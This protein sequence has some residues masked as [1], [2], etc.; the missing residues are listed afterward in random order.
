MAATVEDLANGSTAPIR[1]QRRASSSAHGHSSLL[2]RLSGLQTLPALRQGSLK[3]HLLGSESFVKRL[4]QQPQLTGHDGCVNTIAWDETGEYLLSG[5]DDRCLNIYRPMDPSS[6]LVHSIP[7]GHTHNIFSAKF[8]T[9]SSASTIISC[10][11]DGITRL[12][13]VPR[14]VEKSRLNN[15]VASPGFNCHTAMTYDV[16]PDL[17]DGHIFYD[18]SDDGR[19]NRYDTRISTSCSCDSDDSCHRHTFVNI[20]SHLQS[21]SPAGLSTEDRLFLS[22]RRRRNEIGISAITQRPEN[23]NYIA[24]ACADDTVRIFDSRYATSRDHRVA[25]VYSFSPFVPTGWKLGADGELERGVNRERT[26]LD[27]RITSLKYDP[28]RSGQLL[29]SYSRGNCYLIDPSDLS[30][31]L[32]EQ[33]RAFGRAQPDRE[34][35]DSKGKRRRSPSANSDHSS[36]EPSTSKRSPSSWS[37]TIPRRSS[38][39]Q[40][41]P[42]STSV[43]GAD[44]AATK[45]KLEN[46]TNDASHDTSILTHSLEVPGHVHFSIS[47]ADDAATAVQAEKKRKN[48]AKKD[49][50]AKDDGDDH[51]MTDVGKDPTGMND[52]QDQDDKTDDDGEDGGDEKDEQDESFDS[53][54]DRDYRMDLESD[55]SDSDSSRPDQQD[56]KEYWVR[57][58]FYAGKKDIIKEANFFGPNSEFIMSGS[59]DGRIFFWDKLTGKIINVIKGDRSVVNCLQPH[60]TSSFLLAASG[61]DKTIKIFMPT[62]ENKVDMSKIRGIKRPVVSENELRPRTQVEVPVGE[63]ED[64]LDPEH[65]YEFGGHA[66]S[67]SDDDDDDDDDDLLDDSDDDILSRLGRRPHHL[68][69]QI[70]RQLA[71]ERVLGG[72]SSESHDH[73]GHNDDDDSDDDHGDDDPGHEDDADMH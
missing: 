19:I 49:I 72:D 2:R 6:P 39:S 37:P 10:S 43:T 62:A 47:G 66:N 17:I 63:A 18:C 70:F 4:E 55:S 58:S 16:L 65:A 11:A 27:T 24:A 68:L 69:I 40:L 64:E 26:S 7:S 59:D 21:P 23:P 71:R 36:K 56:I 32:S 9:G 38:A 15:W 35:G 30:P 25:Q 73:H 14:F 29:A 52:K 46:D 60:P 13:N 22:F 67:S 48:K 28:C 41:D 3:H 20:N 12:T 61:I 54:D 1:P 45:E 53:D 42:S 33:P 8:L 31:G 51:D 34:H 50:S 57:R 44:N 5:S